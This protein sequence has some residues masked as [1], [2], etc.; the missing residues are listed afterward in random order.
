VIVVGLNHTPGQSDLTYAEEEALAVHRLLRATGP[1]LLNAAATRGAVRKALPDVRWAHFAC[2]AIADPRDPADSFLALHDAPLRVRDL[3]DQDL[4]GAHLVFLSA[5]STAVSVRL[6]DESIHIASAFQLAGFTHAIATL[7]PVQDE[8]ARTIA[9]Q[10][11][12][13]LVNGMQPARA[14]HDAVRAMRDQSG[15]ARRPFRWAA[16][17]HFGP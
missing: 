17:V 6:L 4:T 5:C 8:A 9:G 14:V 7:W 13:G 3:S 15:N 16:H 10:I 2:H 1:A 11:Y 12:H